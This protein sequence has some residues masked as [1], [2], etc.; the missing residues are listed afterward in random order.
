MLAFEPDPPFFEQFDDAGDV[1]RPAGDAGAD[2]PACSIH[3][4]LFVLDDSRGVELFGQVPGGEF[5]RSVKALAIA[6]A[7]VNNAFHRRSVL[8]AESG[9]LFAPDVSL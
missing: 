7:R 9:G 8:P 2:Q 6:Q 4:E 5:V 3:A 1:V